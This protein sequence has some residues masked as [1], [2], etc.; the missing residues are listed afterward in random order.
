VSVDR[1]ESMSPVLV[2]SKNPISCLVKFKNNNFLNRTFKRA[3]AIEKKHIL[4][5]PINPLY[6][7]K[8]LI[9]FKSI[10]KYKKI[11]P[12]KISQHEKPDIC[13]EKIKV[14]LN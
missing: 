9:N 3:T 1:R 8:H 7:E 10:K 5:P 11:L 14:L 12:Q 6:K 2:L 13:F 4:N